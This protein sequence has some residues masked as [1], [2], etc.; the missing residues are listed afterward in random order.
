MGVLDSTE[1]APATEYERPKDQ[2]STARRMKKG[3]MSAVRYRPEDDHKY[4]N[5]RFGLLFINLFDLLF[6]VLNKISLYLIILDNYLIIYIALTSFQNF[7]DFHPINVN[8]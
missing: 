8:L 7:Y 2:F 6:L 5:E 3:H 4:E 1:F